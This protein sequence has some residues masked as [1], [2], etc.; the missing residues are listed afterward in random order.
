MV[1]RVPVH[2]PITLS[3]GTIAAV[4]TNGSTLCSDLKS[5]WGSAGLN[6]DGVLG[7]DIISQFVVRIDLAG[8]KVFFF[9]RHAPTTPGCPSR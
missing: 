5:V 3:L 8:R 6:I 2:D 4:N 1:K 9:C 7:M